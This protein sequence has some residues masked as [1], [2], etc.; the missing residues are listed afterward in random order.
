MSTLHTFHTHHT[1]NWKHFSI[2]L[3]LY[4]ASR[5][6]LRSSKWSL[7]GEIKLIKHFLHTPCSRRQGKRKRHCSAH[8]WNP[9]RGKKC[10]FS[11]VFGTTNDPET[12]LHADRGHDPPVGRLGQGPIS[13][14]FI[15]CL[16]WLEYCI[17]LVSRFIHTAFLCRI[18]PRI[19]HFNV[20]CDQGPLLQELLFP[21]RTR[22]LF[23]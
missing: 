18:L 21:H 14:F 7:S 15:Y 12:P 8:R 16:F 13:P 9:S 19:M 5:C 1:V 17:K 11:I 4:S 22:L 23:H 2:F 3:R 6:S 20:L 10:L